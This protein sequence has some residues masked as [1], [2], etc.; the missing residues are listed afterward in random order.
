MTKS[1][2]AY[3][4]NHVWLGSGSGAGS[5]C[6]RGERR[7]KEGLRSGQGAEGFCARKDEDTWSRIR[8][9]MSAA[10]VDTD[11][12]W[13]VRPRVFLEG[14]APGRDLI[15]GAGD[16]IDGGGEVPVGHFDNR[17]TGLFGPPVE[18][19]LVFDL[20]FGISLGLFADGIWR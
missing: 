2:R 20:E 19:L 13:K 7:I 9:D 5:S 17:L 6:G 4:L 18:D 15:D 3:G 8:A 16:L 12:N 11:E 10:L 14:D 1:E